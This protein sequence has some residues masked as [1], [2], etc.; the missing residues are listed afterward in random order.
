LDVLVWDATSGVVVGT[1]ELRRS[2][3]RQWHALPTALEGRR[4]SARLD[5]LAL[6]DGNY[7]ARARVVDQAGNERTSD[8]REDGAKMEVTLPVRTPS[9]LTVDGAVLKRKR[10]KKAGRRRARRCRQRRTLRTPRLRGAGKT[11]RGKVETADGRPIALAAI[12]VS[13]EPR[14]GGG[15]RRSGTLQA[16]ARGRFSFRVRRGPSRTIRFHYGGTP[17]VK[18][19]G[20]ELTVLVPARTTIV[21]S[22]RY[23][24]NGRSV[25]FSG[26][27]TGRP[28]PEGGKLID[29]QAFYRHRWRTFATPRSDTTGRW[30]FI[31]RFEATRGLVRYRF[32]ARIRRE[33]AYPY[34]LG[35]S[36][37]ARVTVQGG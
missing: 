28:I 22:K 34:E 11:V 16:D 4:L 17:L 1:I 9:R 29:L 33:A 32:R 25:R 8:Q 2:G 13:E 31:Y 18:P 20:E 12:A 24:R 36:R 26:R 5:D 15:P 14:A 27:L 6:P 3:F 7:E 10:C 19:A 23:V 21:V 30:R 35:H 37:V